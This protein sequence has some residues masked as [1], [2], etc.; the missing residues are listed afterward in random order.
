[1]IAA[2]ENPPPLT[3]SVE[4]VTGDRPVLKTRNR[5]SAFDPAET[6]P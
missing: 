3:L 5:T 4:M 1:L 6:L 2:K